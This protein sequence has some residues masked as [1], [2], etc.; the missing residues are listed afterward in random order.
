MRGERRTERRPKSPA[1]PRAVRRAGFPSPPRP[2]SSAGSALKGGNALRF[3]H[4]NHRST[5]DLDFTAEGD[6]PDNS[7]TI[8]RP[9]E[10]SP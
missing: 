7:D 8:S 6:F 2:R 4:G 10:L 5:L 3:G 9:V 1:S